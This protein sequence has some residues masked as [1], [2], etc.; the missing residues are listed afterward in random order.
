MKDILL[1]VHCSKWQA[2]TQY[3][4]QVDLSLD[5]KVTSQ[6][7]KDSL[8]E[9]DV[10][11]PLQLSCYTFPG[12]FQKE[13]EMEDKLMTTVTDGSDTTFVSWWG[14]CSGSPHSPWQWRD[15][16]PCWAW[17]ADI[18]SCSAPG[19]CQSVNKTQWGTSEPVSRSTDATPADKCPGYDKSHLL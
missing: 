13:P 18:P 7:E 8:W 10:S 6:E 3:F 14:P 16:S 1:Q 5:Y 9:Q 4:L 15:M 12:T 17:C 19:H 2:I 11:G